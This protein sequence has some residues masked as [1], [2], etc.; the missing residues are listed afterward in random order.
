M[1]D[2]GDDTPRWGPAMAALPNDR[3]RRFVVAIYDEDAPRK[4]K[5][6]WPWAMGRA[7]FTFKNS[8]VAGINAQQMLHDPRINLRRIFPHGAAVAVPRDNQ[9]REGIVGKP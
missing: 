5:G 2:K 8:A 9:S 1:S 7:G 3:W 6:L 4:G